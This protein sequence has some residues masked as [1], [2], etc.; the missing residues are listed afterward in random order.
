[1]LFVYPDVAPRAFWMHE[2]LIPLDIVWLRGGRVVDL[3]ADAPAP[4]PGQ[5][6]ARHDGP[7]ADAVLEVPAGAT[8][9]AG[10]AVG[11]TVALP[12]AL[13]LAGAAR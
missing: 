11:D 7:D 2:M 12:P 6:P 4:G 10:L 3:W 5:P 8:A 9:A 13:D 1:M